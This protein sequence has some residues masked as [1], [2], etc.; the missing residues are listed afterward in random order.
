M[1]AS[2]AQ[3]KQPRPGKRPRRSL[4]RYCTLRRLREAA[5]IATQGAAGKR[6]R[7]SNQTIS[8]WE[9]GASVPDERQVNDLLDEYGVT[10][11]LRDVVLNSWRRSA[12]TLSTLRTRGRSS[13]RRESIGRVGRAEPGLARVQL[14][15]Q[16][17]GQLCVEVG[18]V[19]GA[20]L[21]RDTT[22]HGTGPVLRLALADWQRFTRAVRTDAAIG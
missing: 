20:V 13:W 4:R 1:E 6:Q 2:D 14:Q 5:N 3:A 12:A 16:R 17:R 22:Q 11:L 10:G 15:Q 21:I 7:Y 19:P 9:T 18:H 8:R